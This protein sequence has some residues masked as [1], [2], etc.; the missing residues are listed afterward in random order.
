MNRWGS[1]FQ[2]VFFTTGLCLSWV[3]LALAQ[4]GASTR[5]FRP[6]PPPLSPF[7]RGGDAETGGE[8]AP[9]ESITSSSF[10]GDSSLSGSYSLRPF[11]LGRQ[12]LPP[13][14]PNVLFDIKP[15]SGNAQRCPVLVQVVDD[16]VPEELLQEV[17]RPERDSQVTAA[18][19]HS[20][21]GEA[22]LEWLVDRFQLL[23]RSSSEAVWSGA[24]MADYLGCKATGTLS[25]GFRS[26]R[27][28]PGRRGSVRPRRTGPRDHLTLIM[29]G[30]SLTLKLNVQQMTGGEI[31]EAG[32]ENGQPYWRWVHRD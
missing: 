26:R 1:L 31:V 17:S 22:R 21:F 4:Q 19:V 14:V 23:H 6:P 10:D 32:V 24:L 3:S 20:Y 30:E 11:W 5:D 7:V 27:M 18:Q 8:Y 28:L 15:N 9:S 16:L 2:A 13:S 29:N 25:R 12:G